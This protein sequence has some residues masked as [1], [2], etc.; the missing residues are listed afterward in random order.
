MRLFGLVL[1]AFCVGWCSAQSPTQ[2]WTT[3]Y[4]IFYNQTVDCTG[5]FDR[6]NITGKSY[7]I[8]YSTILKDRTKQ[9]GYF[10]LLNGD[11]IQTVSTW[12]K[13]NNP[14]GLWKFGVEFQYKADGSG[15]PM[16]SNSTGASGS[17]FVYNSEAAISPCLP[18]L[19]NNI[20]PYKSFLLACYPGPE[21]LPNSA[22][23]SI[24]SFFSILTLSIL[25]FLKTNY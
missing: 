12:C 16:F 3:T 7:A 10:T 9:P 8:T 15:Y 19:S 4:A 20:L 24:P 11:T 23:S 2:S 6:F 13:N 18:A 21:P 17:T 1:V 14:D 22:S 5:S 25:S